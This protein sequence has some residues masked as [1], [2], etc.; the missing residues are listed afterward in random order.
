MLDP[1]LFTGNLD[2]RI[3]FTT[4]FSIFV[5]DTKLGWIVTLPRKLDRLGKWAE[6]HVRV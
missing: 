4:R 3:E 5:D 6:T 1:V 2:E